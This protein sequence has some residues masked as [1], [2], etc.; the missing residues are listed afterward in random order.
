[1]REILA[2]GGIVPAVAVV[3]DGKLVEYFEDETNALADTVILGKVIRTVTGLHAAFVDIGDEKNAFLPIEE[4]KLGEGA[5]YT[6]LTD[7]IQPG[8]RVLVQ[9]R[10]EAMGTKGAFLSRDISLA[11][12]LVILMPRNNMIGIS[13]RITSESRREALKR[14]GHS[15]THEEFG[16]V[17]RTSSED[18]D[19]EEIVAEVRSLMAVWETIMKKAPVAH[20]PSVIYRKTGTFDALVTD[21]APK[22]IDSIYTN[23][24]RIYDEYSIDYRVIKTDA[25]PIAQRELERECMRALER[26]IWLKSGGNLVI[27]ECEAMTV[28]DVNTAKNTGSRKDRHLLMRTNIDACYEISR[29][30]RL[31]N[32]GG[33]I[34]IDMIDME[35]DDERNTI[36]ATLKDEL[37]KDRIKTVVHGF[38]NLGLIEMTRRR[39]HRKIRDY[40]SRVCP[41]CKGAGYVYKDGFS[42]VNGTDQNQTQVFPVLGEGEA[43]CLREAES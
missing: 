30:L 1:M 18:A 33:I 8:D 19:D 13:S 6:G 5:L 36:L 2:R 3:E 32:I 29:Q 4:K 17:M 35:T 9:V 41:V 40:K 20:A 7:K 34:L 31:R 24:Q 38:T 16:I 12:S 10:R 37:E 28:I 39:S 42:E 21:Y 27:D 15:I 43:A 25:D 23:D 26:R 14:L 11:G 22:G